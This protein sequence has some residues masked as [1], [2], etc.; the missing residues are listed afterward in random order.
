MDVHR[1]Q[2]SSLK[3]SQRGITLII[4]FSSLVYAQ[5]FYCYEANLTNTPVKCY[6]QTTW[7]RILI[8]LEFAFIS[9]IIPSFLMVVFGL[10]TIVNARKAAL[11]RIQPMPMPAIIQISNVN[12]GSHRSRKTE[13]H[14]LIMLFMQV[15]LLTLF[16]LPQAIQNLY[17]NITVYIVK[18]SSNTPINNF[19]F[20]LFFLLTYVTNGMP[21]YIY[22]LTGGTVFRKALL[23]AI[24]ELTHKII[25][26]QN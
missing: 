8:D 20:N 22:T 4:C 12:R 24:R 17:S 10:M 21:F 7:C 25:C 5:I 15:I 13:P 23:N 19:I 18:G 2:M 9:V 16:S 14:L 26:R 6:G 1:R 3:N 11:R